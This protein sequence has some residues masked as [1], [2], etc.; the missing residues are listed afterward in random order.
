[1]KRNVFIGYLNRSSARGE[2]RLCN[3]LPRPAVNL[4]AKFLLT[5]FT[6][7]QLQYID[8]CSQVYKSW[9]YVL[10]KHVFMMLS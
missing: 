8:T 5:C 6:V 1:M 7:D 2:Q 3:E 10:S 9:F 4:L